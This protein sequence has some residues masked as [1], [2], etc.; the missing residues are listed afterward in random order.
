MF[1]ISP[2]AKSRAH[3]SVY[4]IKGPTLLSW[5][6]LHHNIGDTNKRVITLKQLKDLIEEISISKEKYDAKCAE[7]SLP[8]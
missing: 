5:E 7:S 1:R 8:R 3:H 2:G 4:D 6:G